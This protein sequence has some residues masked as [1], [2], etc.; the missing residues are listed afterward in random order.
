MSTIRDGGHSDDG[1]LISRT[2]VS[3]SRE[4]RHIVSVD[5]S[6]LNGYYF[7]HTIFRASG[8][9]RIYKIWGEK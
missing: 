7:I 6:S 4:D 8:E 3:S 1:V 9:L 2:V 5:V